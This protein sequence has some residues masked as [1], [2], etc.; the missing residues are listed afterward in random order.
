MGQWCLAVGV[1][2][3]Q[4][5][6]WALIGR[7]RPGHKQRSISAPSIC[8][9]NSIRGY[10]VLHACYIVRVLEYYMYMAIQSREILRKASSWIGYQHV[11]YLYRYLLNF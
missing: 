9:E 8:Q 1:G 11:Q 6:Q 4:G 7:I 2:A 3:E 5:R 10:K